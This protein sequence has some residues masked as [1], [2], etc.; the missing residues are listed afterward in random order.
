MGPTDLYAARIPLRLSVAASRGPLIVPLWFEW[1]GERFWCASHRDAALI[2]ALT[3]NAICAYDL[4]TNEMPYRGVRGRANVRCLP[5][6]GGAVLERLIDRYLPDRNHPLATWLLS[7]RADEVA[8]EI[9]PFWETC[10]DYSARM[11]GLGGEVLAVD[12]SAPG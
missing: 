3:R 4:S 8:I 10:W 12:R 6:Q 11:A 1:D 9:T 2:S 7:R 5:E